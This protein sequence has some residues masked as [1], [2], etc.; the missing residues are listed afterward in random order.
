MQRRIGTPVLDR[1]DLRH[2]VDQPEQRLEWVAQPHRQR[3]LE[4]DDREVGRLGDGP[5]MGERH[6][7]ADLPPIAMLLGGNTRRHEAPP[8]SAILATRA[9]RWLPSA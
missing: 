8:R 7:G 1:T 3:V 2:L 5:E 6:L 9:A 4:Q